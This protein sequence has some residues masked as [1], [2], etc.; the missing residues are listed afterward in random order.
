MKS[1][2]NSAMT[3]P[4]SSPK[5]CAEKHTQVCPLLLEL[6]LVECGSDREQSKVLSLVIA[7]HFLLFHRKYHTLW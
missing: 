4:H 6:V 7:S 3:V 1:S 5:I 2:T